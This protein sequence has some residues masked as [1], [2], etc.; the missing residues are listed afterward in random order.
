MTNYM[1]NSVI[2]FEYEFYPNTIVEDVKLKL[3]KLLKKEIR[4]FNEGHTQFKPTKDIYKLE[5]DYSGGKKMLE[6]VTAPEPYNVAISNLH[7]ILEFIQ[8]N[9][10][11]NEK[12]A[13]QVNISFANENITHKLNK[14][15]FVLSFNE[16]YVY[17]GF[18]ERKNSLYTKSIKH[19]IPKNK[20]IIENLNNFNSYDYIMPDTKYYGVN[21]DKLKEGYLEFRYL[22]GKDYQ[23]KESIILEKIAYFIDSIRNSFTF[24][25]DDLEKRSLIILH[26]DRQNISEA[27]KSLAN[28]KRVYPKIELYANLIKTENYVDLYYKSKMRDRVIDIITINGIKEGIINYNSDNSSFELKDMKINSCYE[29]YNVDLVSCEVSNG[30]LENCMTFDTKINGSNLTACKLYQSSEANSCKLNDC[31]VSSGSNLNECYIAGSNKF[32]IVLGDMKDCIFRSGVISKST[33]D[34]S[35]NVEFISYTLLQDVNKKAFSFKDKDSYDDDNKDNNI[36]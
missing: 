23:Y 4:I 17:E 32:S 31:Y 11:T 21:F 19:I 26:E 6:L 13:F 24:V 30:V 5:K 28:F 8:R 9:G 18:E 25:L 15:K 7:K 29:L 2:G 27:Y 1:N 16:N 3:E 35:K 20:F 33:L 10:Y 12:S 34:E 22:G 14:L 36:K